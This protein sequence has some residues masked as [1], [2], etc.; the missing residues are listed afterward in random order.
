MPYTLRWS[1]KVRDDLAILPAHHRVAGVDGAV[2]Q[3]TEQPTQP[4]R[5]R[6]LLRENPLAT[7][8]LRLGD[9]RVFYNVDDDQAVIEIVAVGIKTHNQLFI[10]GQEVTL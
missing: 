9:V 2:R 6:K 4:T 8:Q 5:K 3:L 10:G 7:W 1:P